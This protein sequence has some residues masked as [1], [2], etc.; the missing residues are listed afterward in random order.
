[1]N[2][3]ILLHPI[4]LSLTMLTTAFILKVLVD[5]L[6]KHRAEK[7]EKDIRYITHNIKHFINFTMVLLLLFIWAAEIQNFAL[8]IAAFAVAIVLATR[9]YSMYNWLFLLG[10]HTPI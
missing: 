3:D 5:K 8:S 10:H 9:I 2:K 1:M 7:K 6:A 4:L